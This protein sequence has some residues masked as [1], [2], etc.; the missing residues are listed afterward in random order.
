[1]RAACLFAP[2][3]KA[4]MRHGDAA[5][6]AGAAGRDAARVRPTLGGAPAPEG[7][8]TSRGARGPVRVR[9]RVGD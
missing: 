2:R 8:A 6:R 4:A 1:M 9:D 5:E 7:L 3:G